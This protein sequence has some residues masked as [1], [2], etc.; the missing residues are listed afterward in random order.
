MWYP[1]RA[2]SF[3][4]DHVIPQSEAP[5][6]VCDYTN[7]VYACTRCN[8]IRRHLRLID[9]TQQAFGEHITLGSDALFVALTPDGQDVI[10]NLRLNKNPAL[11]ERKNALRIM[12]LYVSQPDNEVV[13]ELFL[14]A[15][16]FPEELPDLPA[17]KP[18]DGNTLPDGVRTCFFVRKT[19]GTL[20]DFY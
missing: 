5:D 12:A 3:S 18:P 17:M 9:P 7:L 4:A 2:A 15:F 11:K 6:R 16:G 14:S 13:R 19:L 1:D 8:S 20:P 10:D